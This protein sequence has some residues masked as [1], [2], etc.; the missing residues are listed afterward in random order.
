[1]HINKIVQGDNLKELIENALLDNRYESVKINSYSLENEHKNTIV[2]GKLT[3]CY[4]EN[5]IYHESELDFEV[6]I[7]TSKEDL[8][9]FDE[10]E[11]VIN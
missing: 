10:F 3:I 2:T 9:L 8:V 7:G 6:N 1:M 5:V 11:V 4:Y